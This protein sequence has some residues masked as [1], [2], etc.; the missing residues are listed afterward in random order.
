MSISDASTLPANS[1]SNS[2]RKFLILLALVVF[3]DFLLFEREPGLNLFLF[4]NIVA[5]ALLI[6][7]RKSLSLSKA[8]GLL[9]L[10]FAAS[11]PLI[12]TLSWMGV[13]VCLLALACVSLGAGGL[14]PRQW[15][16]L[17]L[18][19]LRFLLDVPAR[20]FR[21]VSYRWLQH[22]Q[23]PSSQGVRHHLRGWIMPLGFAAGFLALF[24]MANPLID[25][26][27]RSID[28]TFLLQLLNLWRI[29]FW[30]VVAAFVS[31][32]LYPRLA[33]RRPHRREMPD[34]VAGTEDGLFGHGALLRSLL[35]FN[36]L[37]AVQTLLDLTYLWGGASLPDGMT[38]AEYA[39]RGAYPLMITAI[40]AAV[41]VLVAMRRGGQGDGSALLRG[42]VHLWIAQN[43]LLCLSSILRLDLYVEVYS[44]TE[45]RVA[46]GLWMGLVAIGLFLILLRILLHRSN[47]WLTALSS[48][49]LV[50]TLYA[51]ALA[52]IPAFIARFNVAHSREISGEGIVLDLDYL[53]VLGPAAIPSLDTYLAALP[54][55]GN[56]RRVREVLRWQHEARSLDWRSWTYRAARLDDYLKIHAVLAR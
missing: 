55:D 13:T 10:G 36:V 9:L 46:A 35:V 16:R 48:V 49:T 28:L 20:P 31:L 42:L 6:C 12:E 56:V 40:L 17:P 3:A 52:D 43:I 25:K 50:I 29:G 39:H 21:R 54:A 8:A 18:V 2:N 23:K 32:L 15:T 22:L 37:F 41:F 11:I 44:L 53:A 51:A 5:T 33:R 34:I 45:L 27:L 47:E 30:L 38:H 24:A 14:I 19:L 1:A 4:A 7:S 26:T